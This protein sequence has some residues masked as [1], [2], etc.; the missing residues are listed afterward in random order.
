MPIPIPIVEAITLNVIATLAEVTSANGFYTNLKPERGKRTGNVADPNFISAFLSE[1]TPTAISDA[2]QM[3]REWHQPYTLLLQAFEADT[4]EYP[5]HQTLQIAAAEV[6]E[7]MRQDRTRGGN[8]I[9]TLFDS[10]TQWINDGQS[11]G[12]ADMLSVKITVHYRTLLDNPFA[13]GG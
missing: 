9:N 10:G 5:A 1:D 13:I 4:S 2:P 12:S 3:A 8:A 7:A 6:L 11:H